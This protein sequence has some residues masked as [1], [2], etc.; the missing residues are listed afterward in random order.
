M[1]SARLSSAA[2]RRPRSTPLPPTQE[3][4]SKLYGCASSTSPRAT[5]R[6]KA[7]ASSTLM[8]E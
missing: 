3:P 6:Q 2:C 5:M 7:A 1:M 8:V 4:G